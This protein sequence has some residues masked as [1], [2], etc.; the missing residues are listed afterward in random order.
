MSKDILSINTTQ[1][2]KKNKD[3]DSENEINNQNKWLSVERDTKLE[4]S[5][6]RIYIGTRI[7]VPI[8]QNDN[9]QI[10]KRNLAPGQ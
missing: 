10:V 8:V 5:V 9:V 2:F 3:K 7:F 4:I 1:E 6:P